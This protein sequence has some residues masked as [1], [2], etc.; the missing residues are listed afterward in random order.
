MKFNCST[1][2]FVSEDGK[3]RIRYPMAV[4]VIRKSPESADDDTNP[5]LCVRGLVDSGADSCFISRRMAEWL[6]IDLSRAEK[7]HSIGVGGRFATKTK[8]HLE[9]TYRRISVTIGMVD[10][11]IPEKDPDNVNWKKS[12]L[13]GR[14]QLFK[15]YEITFNDRDATMLFRKIGAGSSTGSA[16]SA[17]RLPR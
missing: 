17:G 16:A 3:I 1:G 12:A 8:M 5:E 4:A 6:K 11:L 10:V 9:I 15:M 14:R 13:L 7:S 2:Y